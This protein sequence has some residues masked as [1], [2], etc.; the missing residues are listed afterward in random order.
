[1]HADRTAEAH[2]VPPLKIGAVNNMTV[3]SSG[4]MDQSEQRLWQRPLP[5]AVDFLSF[6]ENG[7]LSNPPPG[8]NNLSRYSEAPYPTS[9]HLN[10]LEGRWG[11]STQTP[12]AAKACTP[13]L[14]SS[15]AG[16]A[17]VSSAEPALPPGGRTVTLQLWEEPTAARKSRLATGRERWCVATA[18][19][20]ASGKRGER[21]KEGGRDAEGGREG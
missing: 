14:Y 1:M 7:R 5:I 16:A 4:Q 15:S 6:R 12:P 19:S 20:G 13:V 8:M 21:W 3:R 11:L 18:T 17:G 10:H 9:S 2:T